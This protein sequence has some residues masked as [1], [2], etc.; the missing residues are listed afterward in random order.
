M[1]Y[2]VHEAIVVT[3]YREESIDR[4]WAKAR[5]LGLIVTDI[6]RGICNGYHSFMICPDGS[7]SGWDTD[8]MHESLRNEWI[9]WV[10]D[11]SA[12][13]D[14]P[15]EKWD[16]VLNLDWVFVRYGGDSDSAYVVSSSHIYDI[17]E[18]DT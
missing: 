3:A 15:V 6:Q 16:T 2:V 18:G 14:L 9:N 1:G 8:E 17:D 7:K 13:K 12:Y 5:D 10:A 4:A 11:Q